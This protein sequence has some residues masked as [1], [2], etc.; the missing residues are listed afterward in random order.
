[1]LL[2][3]VAAMMILMVGVSV[4]S[5]GG[6][7]KAKAVKVAINVPITGPFGEY[8]QAIRDGALMALKDLKD[9]GSK[10]NLAL[11]IQDN[12]GEPKTAVTLFEK[13]ML[14][15]PD[16]YVTGIKP[17]TMAVLDKVLATGLPYFAYVF[18][19]FITKGHPS[20][21]CTWPTYRFEADK[22]LQYVKYYSAK[23]VAIAC[24][25]FPHALQEF[26]EIV[27]PQLKAMG[28]EADMEVYEWDTK[29]YR[30][31]VVKLRDF[32]PDLYILNG[33]QDNLV[34]F[35]KAMRT[36]N[37]VGDGNV[38][39]TIDLLDA[40]NILTPEELEGL[41]V[42]APEFNIS[43]APALAAW[44]DR[45][46]KT[47]N[48]ASIYSDADA[49]DMVIAI[50]DAAT[51]LKLPATTKQWIDALAATKTEGVNGTVQ[52]D[53]LHD[54]DAHLKIGI[55]HQGKLELDQIEKQP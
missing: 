21:F 13:Q 36:Y 52:F 24:V 26:N 44:K 19:A 34:G 5:C 45:F 55:Y 15:K 11:D 38:I 4:L 54:L 51:R 9:K 37:L 18:D 33:F 41:H 46:K 25:N 48:R 17:Q 49:Y 35:V 30:D 40:A 31:I 10:A 20:M 22:Y 6:S 53:D 12:A 50:A 42:V 47:Y 7:A 2:S 8:G 16:I 39:G 1:M 3:T 14:S 29:D 28:V 32:K 27:I 23:R 43:N